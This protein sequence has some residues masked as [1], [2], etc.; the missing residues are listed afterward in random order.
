MADAKIAFATMVRNEPIFLPIWIRYYAAIVPKSQL[1]IL[2]DGDDQD[3]PAEAEGCQIVTLQRWQ[4]SEGWDDRRWQIIS[5]FA[6]DLLK[7]FDVV[8]FNDVDE[9]LVQDP[10]SGIDLFTAL[11]AA[12]GGKVLTPFALE[13]VHRR[14][15]EP[16]DVRLDQPIL[17]QRRY[18]R[19]NSNYAKPCITSVP[20]RWNLGGHKSTHPELLMPD[21]LYLLHLRYFDRGILNA[22]QQERLDLI[23]AAGDEAAGAGWRH[24]IERITEFMDSFETL[25]ARGPD[26]FGFDW[27]KKRITK[28]WS[29]N[30]RSGFWQHG[31]IFNIKSYQI[32]ERFFGLF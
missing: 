2:L 4:Q 7:N 3:L 11:S 10:A 19:I 9:L 1:F 6:S 21:G 29:G 12:R 26:D 13:M 25:E 31:R 5:E 22:R 8:C 16:E 15:L 24:S 30:P 14:D 20:L 17:G 32:P 28:E 18:A 23:E 27:Q